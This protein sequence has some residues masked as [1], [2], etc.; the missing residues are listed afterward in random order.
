MEEQAGQLEDD[1]LACMALVAK[2]GT[3]KGERP[4][5]PAFLEQLS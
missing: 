1:I 2:R 5:N 3:E 4:T